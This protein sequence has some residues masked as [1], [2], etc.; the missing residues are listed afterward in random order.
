LLDEIKSY[1]FDNLL[2]R[3]SPLLFF[4]GDWLALDNTEQS[5]AKKVVKNKQINKTYPTNKKTN[6]KLTNRQQTLNY[7]PT[8]NIK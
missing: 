6:T 3:F 8:K 4:Q 7:K 1:S 2:T 5:K